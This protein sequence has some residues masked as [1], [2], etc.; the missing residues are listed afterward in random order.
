ME[1]NKQLIEKTA[2]LARIRLSEQ[3]LKEFIPQFKEILE[4]FSKLDEVDVK[5]ITPSFQPIEIKN[6]VREDKTEKCLTREEA[7][8]NSQHK[9]DGYFKGPRVV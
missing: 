1:V 3:E 4:Y 8:K 6:A 2:L 5:N 9:K 7:L